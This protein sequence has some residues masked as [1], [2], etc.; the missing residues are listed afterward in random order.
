MARKK[1]SGLV[2][3]RMLACAFVIMAAGAGYGKSVELSYSNVY[4]AT[5]ANLILANEWCKEIEKRNKWSCQNPDVPRR[6]PHPG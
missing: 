3:G 4:P 6:D 1:L 5:H 2:L